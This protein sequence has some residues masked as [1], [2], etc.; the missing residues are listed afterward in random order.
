MTDDL[1][2]DMVD[3]PVL[4][5]TIMQARVDEL[6]EKCDEQEFY[7]TALQDS[8]RIELMNRLLPYYLSTGSGEKS[9]IKKA[10]RVSDEVVNVL[11]EQMNAKAAEYRKLIEERRAKDEEKRALIEATD[12]DE[13]TEN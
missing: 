5:M 10:R 12:E 2:I 7:I 11:A 13:T 8:H 3:D 6:Q 4:N 9:A 1:N